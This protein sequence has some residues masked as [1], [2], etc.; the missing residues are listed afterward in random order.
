MCYCFNGSQFMPDISIIIVHTGP[1]A[2]SVEL[3]AISGDIYSPLYPSNYARNTHE[4]LAHLL[5]PPNSEI[6]ITFSVFD[7]EYHEHCDYDA[8]E[9]NILDREH[10]NTFRPRR[11]DRHFADGIFKCIFFNENA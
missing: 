11:D 7:V 6:K 9:V 5:A 4:C 10:V 3:T 2:C 8:V 1:K